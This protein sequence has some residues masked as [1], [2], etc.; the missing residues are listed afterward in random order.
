MKNLQYGL[1][2]LLLLLAVSCDDKPEATVELDGEYSGYF[3]HI[4][5]GQTK[6]VKAPT[7]L[8]VK[9]DGTQ[10]SVN[11]TQTRYPAGGSGTFNVLNRKE[12]EFKDENFWT[13]DFDWNLILDGGYSYE[14]KNDS[15]ILTRIRTICATC[16][17][18]NP[19][20]KISLYQYRLRKQSASQSK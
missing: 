8:N 5:P 11:K 13:A 20:G 7:E 1:I 17:Y 19:D 16:D 14:I 2:A 6:V 12:V 9:L 10:F 3:Y 18:I 15:L 4:P